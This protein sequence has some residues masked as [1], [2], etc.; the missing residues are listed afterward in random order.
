MARKREINISEPFASQEIAP[1]E[2]TIKEESADIEAKPEKAKE[3]NAQ[4]YAFCRILGGLRVDYDFNGQKRFKILKSA[5]KR[6]VAGDNETMKFDL[7]VNEYGITQLD[8]QEANAIKRQIENCGFYK[9]G[10]VFFANA[11][12]KGLELAKEF[13]MRFKKTGAE[14]LTADELQKMV[15]AFSANAQ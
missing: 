8:K 7:N 11:Y 9:K 1:Q 10:F 4:V 3:N 15:E 6:A 14:P 5:V 2:E 13:T 12:E